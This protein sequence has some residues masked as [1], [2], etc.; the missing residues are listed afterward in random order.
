MQLTHILKAVFVVICCFIVFTFGVII[1]PIGLVL[2]AIWVL[3]LMF[4]EEEN[5]S[6]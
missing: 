5:E 6:N 3:A 1:V 4:A 2:L